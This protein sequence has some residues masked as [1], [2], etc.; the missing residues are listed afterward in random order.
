MLDTYFFDVTIYVFSKLQYMFFFMLR[1]FFFPDVP[2]A[3]QRRERGSGRT[4]GRRLAKARSAMGERHRHHGARRACSGAGSRTLCP[5]RRVR[6]AGRAAGK[7]SVGAVALAACVGCS[8]SVRRR[9]LLQQ[10]SR[11]LTVLYCSP[12]WR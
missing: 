5:R 9:G 10:V 8:S 11:L 3:V 12:P 6:G 1:Y 2:A 7:V 4:P